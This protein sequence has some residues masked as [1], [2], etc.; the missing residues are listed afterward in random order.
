MFLTVNLRRQLNWCWWNF[1]F[2]LCIL[3]TFAVI[4]VGYRISLLKK[5]LIE[6]LLSKIHLN[7]LFLQVPLQQRN[8]KASTW[9]IFKSPW[10]EIFVCSIFYFL[11][12]KEHDLNTTWVLRVTH[13]QLAKDVNGQ[14]LASLS[15]ETAD[16]QH[17]EV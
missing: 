1:V 7:N 10:A 9:H 3:K 13:T 2:V 8:W 12:V 16:V 15:N 6:L 11:V 4:L 17:S 14:I 5:G